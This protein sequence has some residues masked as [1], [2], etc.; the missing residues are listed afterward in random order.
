MDMKVLRNK[1][2]IILPII[3][4][5]FVIEVIFYSYIIR[6]AIRKGDFA[7]NN[8]KL[9]K[10][11]ETPIFSIDKLYLC[12]SAN[13]IDK[14]VNKNMKDL[15]IYQYADIAIYIN[16]KNSEEELTY[17]N[18]ISKLYIDNIEIETVSDIGEKS[19]NYT[20]S[21]NFGRNTDVQNVTA[22]DKI[23]FDIIYVN[24]E[25]NQADY[26][27]PTFYTDCSNPITLKYINKNI[28]TGYSMDKNTSIS[29]DG[30]LLKQANIAMENIK[31]N[32]RFK[33]NLVNNNDEEFSCWMNF[34]I[35]LDELY[36]KGITIKTAQTKGD[37]YNFF[38]MK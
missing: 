10:K 36:E 16:N 20:N 32:I 12:S 1:S 17:R 5:I 34:D 26:S 35:P 27:N 38:C 4:V 2:K 8:I 22:S 31:C 7:N 30:K 33:I 23:D 29:F 28:V 11:N 37:K 21:L 6:N 19:L 18:T 14:S 15:D 13:A 9:A 25:N 24:S 3:I